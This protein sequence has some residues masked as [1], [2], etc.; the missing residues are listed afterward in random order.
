MKIFGREPTLWIAV[1]AQLILVAG[2]FG[3]HWL[4]GQEAALWVVAINAVAG[5]VTAYAVR[6][7]SPVAFT[8][9]VGSILALAG[10]YGLNLPVET[11][12][13]IN[14]AVVPILALLTRGQVAPQDTKLSAA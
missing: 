13:A 5:A 10:A 9:L 2:T 4:T 7:V 3:F 1:I 12:A 8:Y 6:P 14:A 11:V